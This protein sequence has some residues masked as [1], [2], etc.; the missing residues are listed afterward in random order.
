MTLTPLGAGRVD[1]RQA[2]LPIH[3]VNEPRTNRTQR[4]DSGETLNQ[5]RKA[6]LRGTLQGGDGEVG[7]VSTNAITRDFLPAQRLG[8]RAPHHDQQAGGVCKQ[9]GDDP[10]LVT[11][12]SCNRHQ[13]PSKR[14]VC[15]KTGFYIQR[16]YIPRV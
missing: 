15:R 2:F 8:S 13:P 4:R 3:H 10:G 16:S 9:I 12:H 5:A 1:K 7:G 6:G 14:R 11:R